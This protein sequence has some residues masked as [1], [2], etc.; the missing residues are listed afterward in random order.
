MGSLDDDAMLDQHRLTTQILII[1]HGSDRNADDY[2]CCGLSSVPKE[3]KERTLVISPWFLAPADNVPSTL[4]DGHLLLRWNETG[5][6]PH[7]WRYGA[8]SSTDG[9]TSSFE[10]MD[11]LIKTVMF[12]IYRFT[13]LERII[14]A[15]HSAGGQFTH[16]W[17]L[18]SASS[19]WG[20]YTDIYPDDRVLPL[21]VVAANPRSFCY[22]DNR[23]YQ[24]GSFV[25]PNE[26]RIK[27]CPG[28][29]AWE[30][31]LEMDGRV[32][33][34][35]YVKT[36]IQKHGGAQKLI[37]RHAQ[38]DVVYL[39]GAEDILPVHSEC[40][41]DDF[42]GNTRFQRSQRYHEYL[43]HYYGFSVHKRV[44]A[45]GIPHDHCLL[46]QSQAGYHALFDIDLKDQAGHN[47][48]FDLE[49]IRRVGQVS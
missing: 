40:E 2:L 39:A 35:A 30:W 4:L 24:N 26:Q 36:T 18:T 46:F 28:Y 49:S 19:I 29:N 48:L 3:M 41:D 1:V 12:D 11:V 5:P 47:A 14:V 32:P 31:G 20:D 37:D 42:Q 34:P 15:G 16:R 21:R 23:R 17:A 9:R 25:V 45:M 44:V 6:I 38:R 33:G 7:T 22:L 27:R 10:A 13:R 8:E 43:E